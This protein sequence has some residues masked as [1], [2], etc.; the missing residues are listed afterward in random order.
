VSSICIPFLQSHDQNLKRIAHH[1]INLL[2]LLLLLLFAILVYLRL[3]PSALLTLP[4]TIPSIVLRTFTP[5]ELFPYN[6]R[7]LTFE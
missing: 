4:R 2:L 3:N 7:H 1:T 6:A 5:P